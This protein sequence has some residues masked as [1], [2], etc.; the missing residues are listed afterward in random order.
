MGKVLEVY[1]RPYDPKYPVVSMDESPKQLI[2]DTKIPIK[3][4]RG[5][6]LKYDYEYERCGVCNIFMA[7]NDFIK[8]PIP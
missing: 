3:A 4:K 2:K 6:E 7:I 1:R 8:L 5:S